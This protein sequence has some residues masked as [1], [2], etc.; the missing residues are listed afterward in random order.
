MNT[1][2]ELDENVTVGLIEG[3]G[4][5]RDSTARQAGVHIAQITEKFGKVPLASIRPSSVKA[6]VAKLKKEGHKP[7]YVYA[8]HA[9]LWQILTDAVYEG[10]LVRNPCSRKTAPPM[11][12]QKPYVAT[13]QQIWAL[14]DA[15]PKPIICG[16]TSPR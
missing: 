14:H 6:W 12:K 7:S 2:S 10:L 9:R 4:M 5:N 13:T 1:A 8:L 16:I 11:G 15:F 3:Y